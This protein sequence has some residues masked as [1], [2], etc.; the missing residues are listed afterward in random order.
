MTTH[1]EKQPDQTRI[2]AHLAKE[3]QLPVADVASI[4]EDERAKLALGAHITKYLHIFANRNVR[5]IM[6]KR[7]VNGQGP[8]TG[9]AQSLPNRAGGNRPLDPL[10]SGR[11]KG[12]CAD[13]QW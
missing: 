6:R 12:L 4:Y 11:A 13:P 7:T 5:D 8:L 3:L 2:V 9:A 1:L 10:Q